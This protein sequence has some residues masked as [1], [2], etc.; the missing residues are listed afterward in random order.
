MHEIVPMRSEK[1]LY[2][3]QDKN[4]TFLMS[5]YSLCSINGWLET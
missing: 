2:Y 4:E 3:T 1:I 5:N